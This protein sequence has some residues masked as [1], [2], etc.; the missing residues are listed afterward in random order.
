MLTAAGRYPASG[1]EGIT[2][3]ETG[4]SKRGA[5][6]FGDGSTGQGDSH[7][8]VESADTCPFVASL[9]DQE[10]INTLRSF[11]DNVLS[12]NIIGQIFTHLFYRNA[13]EL[14]A[15]LK[16]HEDLRERVKFLVDE[17][18]SMVGEVANGG[19]ACL[20]KN[21]RKSIVELLEDIKGKGG[22]QLKNDIDLVIEEINAGDMGELFA[23]TIE[24]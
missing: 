2:G 6:V 10:Q 17:Y 20:W 24:N 16:Q 18:S 13:P 21:D 14:T 11:R 15:L 7:P 3:N 8:P 19:T 22:P 12:K 9:D 4:S 5:A 1:L 23:I